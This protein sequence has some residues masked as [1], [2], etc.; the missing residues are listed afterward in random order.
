MNNCPLCNNTLVRKN[1]PTEYSYKGETINIDQPQDYCESCK[2]GFLS[3]ADI[4]ATKIELADFKRKQ[5]G[6]FTTKEIKAVRK[7]LHLTQAE[8]SE[9]FGG[10]V[11]AFY[12]YESGEITQSR[13]TDLLLKLLAKNAININAMEEVI[14]EYHHVSMQHDDLRV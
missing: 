10:G 13:S 2:E 4:K 6:L 3:H 1:L 11:R 7:K 5:D 9:M 8:A 12:R 14:Q